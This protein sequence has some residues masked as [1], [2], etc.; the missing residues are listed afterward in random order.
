M[1]WLFIFFGI[2]C[3]FTVFLLGACVGYT[4]GNAK[5]RNRDGIKMIDWLR[6]S[7][8]V[9]NAHTALQL[10]EGMIEHWMETGE[11]K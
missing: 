3:A 10:T 1:T 9:G 5:L 11:V 7:R 8:P 2:V 6:V 4:E